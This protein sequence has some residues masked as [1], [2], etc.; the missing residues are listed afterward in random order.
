MILILILMKIAV[1]FKIKSKNNMYQSLVHNPQKY[2]FLLIKNY[3]WD[4]SAKSVANH[5]LYIWGINT[6]KNSEDSYKKI[7]IIY[8]YK[9]W[10][11]TPRRIWRNRASVENIKLL[12]CIY[13]QFTITLKHNMK[14]WGYYAAPQPPGFCHE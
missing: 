3:S 8:T 14:R 11:N 4:R 1:T 10:L 12:Y 2:G 13:I 9:H 6:Y 5:V 7:P